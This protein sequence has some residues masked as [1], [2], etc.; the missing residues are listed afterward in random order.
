MFLHMSEILF[1]GR[2]LPQCMLGYTPREQTTPQEHT[3]PP[4]GAV[5]AGRYGQQVGG[6]N[7]T[8]TYTCFRSICQSFCLRVE[9]RSRGV[10]IQV[11]GLHPRWGGRSPSIGYYGIRSTKRN[12]FLYSFIV[13]NFA[14]CHHDY[15]R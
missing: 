11:G 5:H 6:T 2:C 14:A 1:T 10:C 7:P 4:P 3:P 15:S 9:S 13:Q 12:A 8:G